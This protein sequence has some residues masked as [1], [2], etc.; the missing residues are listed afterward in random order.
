M[1]ICFYTVENHNTSSEVTIYAITLD[2]IWLEKS[3]MAYSWPPANKSP[4]ITLII[5]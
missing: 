4:Q 2:S 3:M 5:Y 1:F